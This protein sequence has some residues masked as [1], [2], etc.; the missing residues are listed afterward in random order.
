[1]LNHFLIILSSAVSSSKSTGH[2]LME[3]LEIPMLSYPSDTLATIA[4]SPSLY[5]L[6]WTPWWNLVLEGEMVEE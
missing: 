6:P 4:N 5:P 2:P 1:M 3:S